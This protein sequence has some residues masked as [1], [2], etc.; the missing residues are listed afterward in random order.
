[1]ADLAVRKPV[2]KKVAEEIKEVELNWFTN[3]NGTWCAETDLGWV[4]ASGKLTEE[5]L[6][7]AIA[8]GDVTYTIDENEQATFVVG[9]KMTRK[10]HTS[11]VKKFVAKQSTPME[12]K[13]AKLSSVYEEYSIE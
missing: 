6:D 8:S 13:V 11:S 1:M 7:D 2:T 5:Q 9:Y 3:K 12:R 10:Y 4:V